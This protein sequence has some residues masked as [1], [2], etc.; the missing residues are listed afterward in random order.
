MSSEDNAE[1]WLKALET[2]RRSIDL[3]LD[4]E[5][6]WWHDGRL[7][8]HP[9]LIQAFN[10][11]LA[12]HPDSREAILR[13]GSQWCYIKV[14]DTPFIAH[15]ARFVANQLTATLNTE[16]TVL[17]PKRSLSSVADS[18]YALLPDGRLIRFDRAAL[19]TLAESLHQSP[20]GYL[21]RGP[22]GTE[23]RIKT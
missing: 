22:D 3:R 7:F 15:R 19:A 12:L 23:W 1:K 17:I 8:E 4:R 10:R 6:R 11:G 2:K 20:E 13:V 16:E 21:L 18:I 9:R 14:E 5:G